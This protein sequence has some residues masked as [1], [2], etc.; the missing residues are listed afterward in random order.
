MSSIIS[1]IIGGIVATLTTT[2]IAR[3]VG[4]A[5][6][7]G[8]LK[9]ATFMWCLAIACVVFA[10]LPVASTYVAGHNKEFWAKLFLFL[11]FGFAAVYCFGEAAWVQG[12]FDHVGIRFTTP[13][14]GLKQEQ[15]KDLVSID[16]S[17]SASWYVLTFKSG[18]KIRLSTYLS[19]HQAA[20]EVA[21]AQLTAENGLP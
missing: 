1:G 19:G 18:K 3:N 21:Q 11:G 10:L 5:A 14:T 4:K 9:Y 6:A 2:V 12:S 7:P 13:W 16:F 15:W 8:Q 20:L 17:G